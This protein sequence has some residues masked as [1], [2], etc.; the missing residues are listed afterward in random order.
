MVD[1]MGIEDW[2]FDDID[3]DFASEAVQDSSTTGAD[4]VSIPQSY[5]SQI[6]EILETD[7][8]LLKLRN[9]CI[10]V[11][12]QRQANFHVHE[13]SSNHPV[14]KKFQNFEEGNTIINFNNMDVSNWNDKMM[15]KYLAA[16]DITDITFLITAA[17]KSKQK[18]RDMQVKRNGFA[19]YKGP[20][21]RQFSV[22]VCTNELLCATAASMQVGDIVNLLNEQTV[23]KWT[24][25]QM[26]SYLLNNDINNVQYTSNAVHV[27]EHSRQHKRTSTILQEQLRTGEPL[28]LMET[29]RVTRRKLTLSTLT[30]Q[31]S[32][33]SSANTK[34]VRLWN[35]SVYWTKECSLC[36]C[37][38][39]EIPTTNVHKS[40]CL[41][42]VM[43]NLDRY[44]LTPLSSNMQALMESRIE[45]LSRCSHLLNN[46]LS[47][48]GTK[49][50]NEKG[51]GFERNMPGDHCVKING[52]IDHFL[53]HA[54]N[55]TDP[56]GGI[57]YLM[58]A[59][60]SSTA[61]NNHI[62]QVNGGVCNK[63]SGTEYNNIELDVLTTLQT[64]IDNNT[65]C[66][67]ILQS[68]Y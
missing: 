9:G 39:L 22:V 57:S 18:V 2:D 21:R 1:N 4:N 47:F 32:S 55:G 53:P 23:D 58:F 65:I 41:G 12:T 3:A 30:V 29:E 16:N 60:T 44:R 15:L 36:G 48:G 6:F 14:V 34:H 27:N 52:R 33:T 10:L 26:D 19:L 68:N 37:M 49:V 66:I 20:G 38:H 63:D 5:Y 28:L 35:L 51:G 56:S 62:L 43:V 45:Y 31:H 7:N 40:C 67:C 25:E 50:V 24:N 59:P 64:G 61:I 42:G 8:R 11:K 17:Q 13:C 54:D 46:F